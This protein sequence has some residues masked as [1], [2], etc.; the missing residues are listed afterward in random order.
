MNIGS[1]FFEIV[2]FQGIVA[3]RSDMR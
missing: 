1:S 3:P 2:N